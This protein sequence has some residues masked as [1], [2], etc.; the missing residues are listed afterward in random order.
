MT[1]G[2]PQPSTPD[3]MREQRVQRNLKIVVILL[4]M[5][6]LLGLG[7]VI[8]KVTGLAT[9][10]F[11]QSAR[12]G[13]TTTIPASSAAAFNLEIPPGAKVV[14]ISISG[15]RLAVYYEG[16][17]E[18]GIAVIDIETGQRVVDVK[19]IGALPHN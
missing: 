14:S 16:G 18:P 8:A 9:G 6:I 13:V 3:L 4:G 15:S 10:R 5:L 1:Q 12:P 7:A 19:P 11:G 2:K 17:G